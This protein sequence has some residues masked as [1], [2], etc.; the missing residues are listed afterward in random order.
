MLT[1]TI[2]RLKKEP[3]VTGLPYIRKLEARLPRFEGIWTRTRRMRSEGHPLM[4]GG[5]YV[6]V[7][8]SNP[9]I[10]TG[11]WSK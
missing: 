9:G 7:P 10:S 5:N 2:P 1:E 3:T 6:E 4:K 11:F 8:K